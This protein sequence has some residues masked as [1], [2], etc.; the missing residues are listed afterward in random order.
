MI[1]M[2]NDKNRRY[3]IKIF[4]NMTVL[5]FMIMIRFPFETVCRMLIIGLLFDGFDALV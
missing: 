2:I 1:E 3:L 5:E 4:A